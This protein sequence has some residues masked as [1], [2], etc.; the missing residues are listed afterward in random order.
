MPRV[1]A[2][3][4]RGMKRGTGASS[5]P[6]VRDEIHTPYIHDLTDLA[7]FKTVRTEEVLYRMKPPY[8]DQGMEPWGVGVA[9]R[10]WLTCSPAQ[11][12]LGPSMSDIYEEARIIEG[13]DPENPNV[14]IA[15][16]W[17]VMRMHGHIKNYGIATNWRDVRSFILLG[18]GPPILTCPWYEDMHEPTN[19][20]MSLHGKIMGWQSV[21]LIGWSGKMHAARVQANYGAK[22]SDAG[23]AWLPARALEMLFAQGATVTGSADKYVGIEAAANRREL[24]EFNR[25][26]GLPNLLTLTTARRTMYNKEE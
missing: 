13:T 12:G 7:P 11:T 1:K 4:I 5:V 21:L 8:L 24:E 25:L 20:V 17:E 22:W 23:K 9:L 2:P 3:T 16:G 18:G 10:N 19:Q 14:S 26:V 15:S 6:P